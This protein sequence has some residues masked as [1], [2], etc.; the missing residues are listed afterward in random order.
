M[1]AVE[2]ALGQLNQALA[3][4]IQLLEEE[5]VALAARDAERLGA[6][7]PRR[8]EIHQALAGRWM[9]LAR[10][11]GT[12]EPE[13]LA[14]MRKRLFA[15]GPVSPGW[16]K[17][18]ELAQVSDRLN[19]INGRL[20]EE[21]MRRTQAAM[22]VLQNS[23]ASRGVYGADGKVADFMNLNRRIDSA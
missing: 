13:G 20:I 21:Q 5:A 8:N 19:H 23:L 16:R 6:L 1:S 3:D 11:A 14:D 2:H 9:E 15:D 18:E 12:D 17:L 22:Q 4:F 10:L 7:L